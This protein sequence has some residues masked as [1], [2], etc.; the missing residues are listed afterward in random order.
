MDKN[1]D[2]FMQ[3][4]RELEA[5]PRNYTPPMAKRNRD[6]VYNG[7]K[8]FNIG[9]FLI[10]MNNY[11]NGIS[12]KVTIASFGI[13]GPAST[14][15]LC[16]DGNLVTYVIDGSRYQTAEFNY[17]SGCKIVGHIRN[18]EYGH[19][20]MIDFNLILSDNKEI[21]ILGIWAGFKS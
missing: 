17:Y 5:L 21:P 12:D 4:R 13:D 11:Y 2:I 19:E 8:N 15:V 20:A 1:P 7:V 3:L 9:R 18:L 6:I 16:Y 10:F 14:A